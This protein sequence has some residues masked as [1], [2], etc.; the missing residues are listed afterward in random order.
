MAVSVLTVTTAQG[1]E[2]D[3]Y[4]GTELE[5]VRVED[6]TGSGDYSTTYYDADGQ[7]ILRLDPRGHW[8]VSEYDARG[9]LASVTEKDVSDGG[10]TIDLVTGYAYDMA[11]NLVEV[12]DGIE[13]GDTLVSSGITA[14]A[15]G[16]DLSVTVVGSSGGAR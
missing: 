10:G 13:V 6:P 1:R 3:P 4:D 16:E 14:L 7:P 15:R 5:Y 11:D 8:T 9:R 12:T 2:E